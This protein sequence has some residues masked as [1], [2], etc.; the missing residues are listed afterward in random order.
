MLVRDASADAFVPHDDGT[1]P[2]D[3]F[4]DAVLNMDLSQI[5]LG[6]LDDYRYQQN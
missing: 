2:F 1:N 3:G 4:L 6:D 5:D